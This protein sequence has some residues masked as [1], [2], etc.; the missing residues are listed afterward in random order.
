MFEPLRAAVRPRVVSSETGDSVLLEDEVAD[1]LA[2][3]SRMLEIVGGPGSG[4][5][6]ALRH[7]AAVFGPLAGVSWLDDVKPA[8]F[9]PIGRTVYTTLNSCRQPDCLSLRLAAWTD[10]ELLEY[11]L[12]RHRERCT[13][14]LARCRAMADGYWS[15][16]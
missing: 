5:T 11:C 16:G 8:E 9:V 3:R 4:K 15:R 13:S 2:S 1:W 6:T 12:S 7:L 10:D 14:I